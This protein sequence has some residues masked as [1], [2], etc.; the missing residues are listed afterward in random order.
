MQK[1]LNLWIYVESELLIY[2]DKNKY[3]KDDLEC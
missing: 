2:A 3:I 1:T